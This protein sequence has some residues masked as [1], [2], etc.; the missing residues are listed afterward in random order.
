MVILSTVVPQGN[1]YLIGFEGE[2]S[3]YLWDLRRIVNR[4][5]GSQHVYGTSTYPYAN[6]I[7][8]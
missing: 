8:M 1:D 4:E 7:K 2:G 5:Y 3:A 6:K